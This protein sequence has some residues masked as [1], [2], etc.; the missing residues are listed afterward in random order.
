MPAHTEAIQ[1]KTGTRTN[2]FQFGAFAAH[3]G[4]VLS[5]KR[6]THRQQHD[7]IPAVNVLFLLHCNGVI[8]AHS[9]VI[10]NRL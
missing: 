4:P 7:Q 2:Q 9:L 1:G 6:S 8:S 3:P 5:G 10:K